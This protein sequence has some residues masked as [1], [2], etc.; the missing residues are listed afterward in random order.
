MIQRIHPNDF[1]G[2]AISIWGKRWFLLS[3][4]DFENEHYNTM[5]VAWGSFGNMW[6][7]PFAQIVVRPTRYTYDFCETYDSFTLCSFPDRYRDQVLL[8]GRKS[9]REGDKLDESGLTPIAAQI[10]SSP[11]FEEADLRIECSKMYFQDMNPK[12]FLDP[13][14]E[15]NYPLNDYHRIYFGKIEIIQGTEEFL[16]K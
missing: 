7:Y 15:H 2:S 3:C 12:H 14:I 4:G 11:V 16:A 5:V 10:V 13:K 1:L 8:L 9:G 6:N